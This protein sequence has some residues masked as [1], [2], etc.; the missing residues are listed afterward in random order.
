MPKL[1]KKL[2]SKKIKKGFFFLVVL[3]FF[4]YQIFLPFSFYAYTARAEENTVNQE[5]QAQ[6]VASQTS[7][8]EETENPEDFWKTCDLPSEMQDYMEEEKPED[9]LKIEDD[10]GKISECLEIEISNENEA[11]VENEIETEAVSG[12][13]QI[14]GE[15]EEDTE[16]KKGME[17]TDVSTD[18]LTDMGM[19]EGTG[20]DQEVCD[21]ENSDAPCEE[22]CTNEK[23]ENCQEDSSEEAGQTEETETEETQQEENKINTGDAAAQSNAYNQANVNIVGENYEL[24]VI[25]LEGEQNG[26]INLYEDFSDINEENQEDDGNEEDEVGSNTI[27]NENTAEITNNVETSANTGNNSIENEDS[28][29]LSKEETGKTEGTQPEQKDDI[30]NEISTGNATAITN[31][32]NFINANFVGEN[33]LMALINVFGTWNG[34]LVVPGYGTIDLAAVGN[35]NLVVENNNTAFIDNNV[36][37]SAIS[38]KN[39]IDGASGQESSIETGDA[40]ADSQVKNQV[41]TNIV[42]NNW[43]FVLVNNLGSWTGKI[44]GLD[45]DGQYYEAMRYDLETEQP[46]NQEPTGT[47]TVKNTNYAEV[48]NDVQTSANTGENSISGSGGDIETGNATALSRIFN[49]IN[50]NIVGNNWFFAM[51]NVFGAWN[52]NVEQAYPDLAVSIDDGIAYAMPADEI[53]YAVSVANTGKADAKNVQIMVALD[54]NLQYQGCSESSAKFSSSENTIALDVE[55]LDAGQ[56]LLFSI[57]VKI[58]DQGGIGQ[59]QSAI[60]AKTSTNEP[61]LENNQASDTDKINNPIATAIIGE[62]KV[63]VIKNNSG[64]NSENESDLDI[65]RGNSS[66][67]S[68]QGGDIVHFGIYV[69]NSKNGYTKNVK[70][71]DTLSDQNGNELTMF[72][73]QLGNMYPDNLLLVT[74]DIQINPAYKGTLNFKAKARGENLDGKEVK[75]GWSLDAINIFQVA[76]AN[77]PDSDNPEEAAMAENQD[78]NQPEVMGANDF[79]D[80]ALPFW[81]WIA[82]LAS[83]IL[84]IDWS[85]Y[86]NGRSRFIEGLN[87]K[88][89]APFRPRRTLLIPGIYTALAVIL[90]KNWGSIE[91]WWFLASVAA[92]FLISYV[93]YF[94]PIWKKRETAISPAFYSKVRFIASKLISFF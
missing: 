10:C 13:N 31:I 4:T 34:N 19:Q 61:E 90:W 75:S 16:G 5:E 27:E 84:A 48:E 35:K 20:E 70:L 45:D 23:T 41:N 9:C 82:A 39:T 36:A 80:Q 46:Q 24:K 26:D 47:L 60:A 2:K 86:P 57:S 21:T 33:W 30:E 29:K 68:A 66:S 11:E 18:V 38:G 93:E 94:L 8:E 6:E 55:R 77:Q 32:M 65:R 40:V 64:A 83:Y 50:T 62:P 14:S 44:M 71:Q 17:N 87:A 58:K 89:S 12:E 91:N 51:I 49:F 37:T 74:Y 67:G 7:P 53:T 43:F 76:Y 92:I 85:L 25:N 63:Q 3:N 79:K 28:E 73:W 88:K 22:N 1:G 56:S 78:E 42:G 54:N 15:S 69:E 72:E 81:I 52:G 59:I